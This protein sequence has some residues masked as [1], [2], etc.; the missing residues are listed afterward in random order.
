MS[1]LKDSLEAGTFT[2]TAELIPPK[3]TNL[4]S[5]FEKAEILNGL[6]TA[7]NLTD[8]Y[9]A[10]MSMSPL[11]AARLLLD[12]GIE[13]ILQFTCRDRNRIALQGDLL[14][15]SALGLS[16]IMCMGGDPPTIGDHPE[17]K[18]VF[19]FDAV[20]LLGA[21]TT[22]SQGHDIHDNPLRGTPQFFTGAVTN[23]GADD[24]EWEINRLGQKIDAGA[25]FFQ[26]QAVYESVAYEKFANAT[27]KYNVPFLPSII[28]LKSGDMARM[29][30]EKVPGITVPDDIVK[31]MDDAAT[32]EEKS[33]KS[34]EI[35]ART[36]R[37]L[38]PLCQGVHLIAAGWE[39]KL[40]QVIKLATS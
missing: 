7:F 14:G 37:E 6:V 39:S 9:T 29:F 18:P 3:G 38:R 10:K 8:S 13:S 30:N 26:T 15:A 16:N 33:T 21:I 35:A 31:E 40:P 32:P 4:E 2:Y 5:M 36:I 27:A 12:R 11:A 28:L 1:K 20:S 22:L 34:I 19:D 25:Q 23:P 17:A 24:L